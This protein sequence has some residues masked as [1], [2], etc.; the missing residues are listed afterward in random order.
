MG[1]MIADEMKLDQ[2]E[3]HLI[4]HFSKCCIEEVIDRAIKTYSSEFISRKMEVIVDV[5]PLVPRFIRT[6]EARLQQVIENLIV[7]GLETLDSTDMGI[8]VMKKPAHTGAAVSLAA[9]FPED[10]I[11]DKFS[12]AHLNLVVIEKL[13]KLLSGTVTTGRI[14]DGKLLITISLPLYDD[15]TA[16][17]SEFE[18]RQMSLHSIT[19]YIRSL[20]SSR[21][22]KVYSSVTNPALRTHYTGIFKC[23]P[24]IAVVE[25]LLEEVKL[26]KHCINVLLLDSLAGPVASW[27]LKQD[28]EALQRARFVLLA[29]DNVEVNTRNLAYVT[30]P[31]PL[32]DNAVM[33]AVH[34]AIIRMS[35]AIVGTPTNIPG[36][37]PRRASTENLAASCPMRIM[38]VEDSFMNLQ[39][40]R[41]RRLMVLGFSKDP[42][43]IRIQIRTGS[44]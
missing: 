41:S 17:K 4:P 2:N 18:T 3:N 25:S 26:N 5:C 40:T 28:L 32:L 35:L 9:I 12:N 23:I 42:G 7:C 39:V 6:D 31:H 30:I 27:A 36:S 20:R 24:G 38:V 43:Q 10:S 13:A 37:S 11:V 1:G 44:P 19:S 21:P 16:G 15:P 8:N 29:N 33:R 14:G 22:I 34:E